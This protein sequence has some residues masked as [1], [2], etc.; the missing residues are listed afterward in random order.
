[1]LH[2][3]T[4]TDVLL[5]Q[6]IIA[7][8][9]S[10]I[11]FLI[12]HFPCFHYGRVRERYKTIRNMF[13][14]L[15]PLYLGLYFSLPGEKIRLLLK[16][17]QLPIEYTSLG[18]GAA[19]YWFLYSGY[20]SFYFIV[21]RSLSVR[22]LLAIQIAAEK[23]LSF[24]KLLQRHGLDEYMQGRLDH[25]EYGN[26]IVRRANGYSNT[27]RGRWLATIVRVTRTLLRLDRA[28]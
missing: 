4:S 6:A 22:I 25:L 26:H 3:E 11:V 8:L 14:A 10:F 18:V 5:V 27:R 1:M 2:T 16:T 19:L 24:E 13:L 28:A 7:A 20:C 17:M 21:D 23:N 9:A 12:V 15:I